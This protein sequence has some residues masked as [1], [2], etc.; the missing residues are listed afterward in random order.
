MP[1]PEQR[2]KEALDPDLTHIY[3]EA[4]FNTREHFAEQLTDGTYVARKYPLTEATIEQHLRGQRTIGV[5][6]LD[7]QNRAKWLCFDGDDEPSF[8]DLKT[9]T[10]SLATQGIPAYLEQSRRGGHLWLFLDSPLPG[11]AVRRYARHLLEENSITSIR[12]IYPRQDELQTGPGS[13]VRLP[14]GIHQKDKKRYGFV[15]IEGTP[16]AASI[17]AQLG[18]FVDLERASHKHILTVVAQLPKEPLPPKPKE[19]KAL[20]AGDV[21]QVSERIKH[22]VSVEEFVSHFVD[23]DGRGRGLCPFHDDHKE[24]FGVNRQENFWS[25][26]AQCGEKP[27]GGSVIHFWQKYRRERFGLDGGFVPT[28]TELA[29]MLL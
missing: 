24:S 29:K 25:C 19:M 11:R 3:A 22:A 7:G 5:Y 1:P 9:L 4:F 14:L 2:H 16:L 8:Q 6:A 18:L 12:E 23:L 27:H 20:L 10:L 17:R 15:T 26:F 21:G 13:L 28:I